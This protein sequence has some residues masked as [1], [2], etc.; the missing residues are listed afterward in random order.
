MNIFFKTILD[1]IERGDEFV[2][3]TIIKNVGS[4]PRST[5]TRMIVWQDGRIAG[6]IGGGMLEA[7]VIKQAINVAHTHQDRVEAYHFD[8]K[9]AGEAGMLCGGQVQVLFQWVMPHDQGFTHIYS[10]VVNGASGGRAAWLVS[11]IEYTGE[12]STELGSVRQAVI[13]S[14]GSVPDG[15]AIG[16]E[17]L[18]SKI[19][20]TKI[21]QPTWLEVE[22]RNWLVEPVHQQGT[23]YLFGGGHVSQQIAPLTG[24]V[25]FQTVV[26]DD[27]P[28]FVTSEKFPSA[29]QRI[30]LNSFDNPLQGL[31]IDEHSFIVVVTRGHLNDRAVVQQAVRSGAGFVGMIGS[32]HKRELVYQKMRELGYSE[33]ELAR[34]HSPIGLEIGAETP[35][36]I[37]ISILAEL[38]KVRAGLE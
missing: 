2:L 18:I 37:A 5:G 9:T 15:Q 16:L 11:Q 1:T 19:Q 24:W 14:D 26:L 20:G 25:G 30:L 29:D 17:S 32:R 12:N 3:T 7:L 21:K 22:G 36:E 34:I 31:A 8:A 35:E 27:R 23:V 6:T 10:A 4:S 38:I 13:D 33:V 28:E